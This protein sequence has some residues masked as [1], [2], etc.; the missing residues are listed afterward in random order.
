MGYEIEFYKTESG[1]SPVEEFIKSLQVK[2]AAKVVKDIR[3][4]KDMGEELHYPYVDFIKGDKYDGLME[5][6][7]KQSNN[8]FRTFYFVIEKKEKARELKAVLLHAIQ[9]KTDKTPKKELETA[10]ARMKD[11]KSRR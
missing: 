4:L 8:I 3:L 9:K 1:R 2:H 10:L 5:L 7:T 11:Y 6:R